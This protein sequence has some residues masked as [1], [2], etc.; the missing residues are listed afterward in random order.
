[1]AV[2]SAWRASSLARRGARSAGVGPADK[3][4]VL[5]GLESD[6]V[7]IVCGEG[8]PTKNVKVVL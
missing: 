1:M 5:E 6:S 2:S 8:G 3:T 7:L 4:R